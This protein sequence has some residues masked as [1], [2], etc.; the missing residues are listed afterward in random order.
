LYQQNAR[1]LGSWV[2]TLQ[3]RCYQTKFQNRLPNF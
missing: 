3:T 1:I 2:L